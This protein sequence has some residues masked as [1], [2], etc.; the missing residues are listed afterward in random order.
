MNSALQLRGK[1]RRRQRRRPRR[2]WRQQAA[3]AAAA[4]KKQAALEAAAN[5]CARARAHRRRFLPSTRC[6][7]D[8]RWRR[9]RAPAR[10]S[11]KSEP[12][13][14][15]SSPA[16]AR[17]AAAGAK[18]GASVCARAR[19]RLVL[20]VQTTRVWRARS[21][22]GGR[23]LFELSN[24]RLRRATMVATAT[25]AILTRSRASMRPAEKSGAATAAA[26]M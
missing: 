4:K 12:L 21:G 15:S 18:I 1:R 10:S 19:A 25:M 9:R 11:R 3:A 13:V 17:A 24:R 7:G 20:L 22:G 8:F 23:R 2:R 6:G 16:L 26:R 14:C 5:G